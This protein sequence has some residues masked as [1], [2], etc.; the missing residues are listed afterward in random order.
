MLKD[1]LLHIFLIAALFLTFAAGCGGKKEETPAEGEGEQTAEGGEGQ[2]QEAARQ[3]VPAPPA[4]APQQPAAAPQQPKP[5][6]APAAP[7]GKDAKGKAFQP[8][9]APVPED[10]FLK[11]EFDTK[12]AALVTSFLSYG[13]KA[14]RNIFRDIKSSQKLR[15]DAESAIDQAKK[16]VEKVKAMPVGTYS[17]TLYKQADENYKQAEAAFKE[18]N[19]FKAKAIAEKASE[20]AFEAIPKLGPE[21][22]NQKAGIELFYKGFYQL[23]DEK[24]AMLTKK[25]PDNG[26]EKLYTVKTGD[27]IA[28]DLAASIMVDGPD[29]TQIKTNKIEYQIED[30]TDDD[31]SLSNITEKKP[32]FRIQ[33]SRAETDKEKDKDKDKDKK[34]A[35][36]DKDKK[37]ADASKSSFQSNSTGK[38][39]SSSSSTSSGGSSSS[40]SSTFK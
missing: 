31:I 35:D 1:K 36:K 15:K 12:E 23:G 40:F 16:M 8:K 38:T 20:L 6:A 28:Q 17:E 37:A 11:I 24:T 10:R 9:A 22:G 33:V 26:T 3:N 27:I 2:P 18:Q 13:A 19:Y 7:G 21:Q 39:G 32:A 14:R 29:G 25:D 5:P 34:A 30:I 4:G